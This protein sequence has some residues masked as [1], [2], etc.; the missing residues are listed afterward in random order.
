MIIDYRGKDIS[1]HKPMIQLISQPPRK[2][3][4]FLIRSLF[5]LFSVAVFVAGGVHLRIGS[6]RFVAITQEG[7]LLM[8]MHPNYATDLPYFDFRDR[9]PRFTFLAY[10]HWPYAKWITLPIWPVL[11]AWPVVFAI[12]WWLTRL[13]RPRSKSVSVSTSW[14]SGG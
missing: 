8:Q 6:T 13:K 14:C 9:H 10:P 12:L 3:M 4:F 7:I 1:P 11:V 5:V 2:D